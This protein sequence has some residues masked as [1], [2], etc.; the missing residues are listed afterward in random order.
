MH[1]KTRLA[2][3]TSTHFLILHDYVGWFRR[4]RT[5]TIT[6][7]HF[8][9]IGCTLTIEWYRSKAVHGLV[10]TLHLMTQCIIAHPHAKHFSFLVPSRCRAFMFRSA[11]H[12]MCVCL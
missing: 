4:L 5:T 12:G 9:W 1:S 10:D 3:T 8:V 11:R 7:L 6:V 2:F